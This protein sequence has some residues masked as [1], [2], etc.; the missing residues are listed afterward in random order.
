MD[1]KNLNFFRLKFFLFICCFNFL[2]NR[3]ACVTLGLPWKVWK[4]WWKMSYKYVLKNTKREGAT[5]RR[6]FFSYWDTAKYFFMLFKVH[7]VLQVCKRKPCNVLITYLLIPLTCAECD[8][9]LPFL[10]SSSI[11]FCY[12]LF[13]VTL[14][15]QLFFHPLSPNLA[16]YFLVYLSVLLFPNS[17]KIPFWEFCFL[18]MSKPM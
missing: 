4:V 6:V 14:L 9:S 2:K 12:V 5:R 7:I 15:H 17:Y 8:D 11:P 13:P 16:I 10:G 1:F 18:Y 3:F